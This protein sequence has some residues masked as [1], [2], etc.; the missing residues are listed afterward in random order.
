MYNH[1]VVSLNSQGIAVRIST[2]FLSFIIIL[3]AFV[4]LI[5]HPKWASL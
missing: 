3:R 4:L 1:V 5:Q 2:D